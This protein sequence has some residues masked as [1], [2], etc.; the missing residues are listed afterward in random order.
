LELAGEVTLQLSAKSV[1]LFEAFYNSL[2]PIPL[3]DYKFPIQQSGSIKDGKTSIPFQFDL[4]PLTGQ[5]LYET[6]HGVYVNI[7]YVIK[8][9]IIRKY[10]G[11]NLQTSLEFIVQVP[12]TKSIPKPL[13]EEFTLT[14]DAVEGGRKGA[15]VPEFSVKGFLDSTNLLIDKPLT[16]SII[17]EKCDEPIKCIEVQLVR[18]ET[19][20]CSDGWAK[21]ATE[22]QNIQI[23]E[24]DIPRGIEVPIHMVFPRL[25]TCPTVISARTFKIEF[26]V[27]LVIMFP[28][29]RLVS[30][31][32]PVTLVR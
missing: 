28:D 26:Q 2:K 12:P 27:N 17:L 4:K 5:E 29:G 1:G 13:R 24:G 31:K 10:L 21:E 9:Q 30:K 22:I 25:F 19:C 6:Y 7:I 32:F 14:P 3:I 11:K 20:G 23:V 15:S 16:G 18:V 8:A